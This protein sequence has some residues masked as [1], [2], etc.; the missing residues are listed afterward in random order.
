MT[1]GA[2]RRELDKRGLDTAGTRPILIARLSEALI[3]EEIHCKGTL[4]KVEL[5]TL[6]DISGIS[7]SSVSSKSSSLASCRVLEAAKL[8]GLKV[9]ASALKKKH[10][11][12]K[13]AV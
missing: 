5:D 1:R 13:Q 3:P 8:A 6:S 4:P 7:V 12:D 2:L 11:L 10:E 9:R